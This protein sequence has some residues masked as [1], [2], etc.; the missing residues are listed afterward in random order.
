MTLLP[1]TLP[2][3]L[4]LEQL[5]QYHRDP[6]DRLLIAQGRVES[7]VIASRDEIFQNLRL[8]N[9][10]VAAHCPGFL[11]PHLLSSIFPF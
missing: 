5:P 9:Y 8:H 4:E 2:H 3:I 6:F 11:L 10:L 7:A 1:I